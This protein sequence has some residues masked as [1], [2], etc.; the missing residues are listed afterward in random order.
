MILDALHLVQCYFFPSFPL[1]IVGK[2][3]GG[4]QVPFIF[5]FPAVFSVAYSLSLS[6]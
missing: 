2:R 3:S 5:F 4:I 1:V 6:P